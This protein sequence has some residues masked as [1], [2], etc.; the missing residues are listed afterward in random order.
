M[1]LAL[2]Y[3]GRSGT[4]GGRKREVHMRNKRKALP[5]SLLPSLVVLLGNEFMCLLLGAVVWQ[6]SRS[7][8][9]GKVEN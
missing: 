7:K 6:R 5:P 9:V 3:R 8:G 4:A 1:F 2:P